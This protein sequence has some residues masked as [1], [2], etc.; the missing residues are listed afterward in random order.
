MRMSAIDRTPV[1]SL[2]RTW[3]FVGMQDDFGRDGDYIV[4]DV[5]SSTLVVLRAQGSLRAFHNLCRHRRARLLEGQANVGS[6][7]S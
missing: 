4:C 3:Q 5:G 2:A 1:I 7:T 6:M